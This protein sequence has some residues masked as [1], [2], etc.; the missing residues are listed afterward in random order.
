M[1]RKSARAQLVLALLQAVLDPVPQAIQ[2]ANLVILKVLHVRHYPPSRILWQRLWV[3]GEFPV[4]LGA[5]LAKDDF[6]GC[7]ES[8]FYRR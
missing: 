2:I 4:L 1:S 3:G 7:I 8:Q 5:T 6:K